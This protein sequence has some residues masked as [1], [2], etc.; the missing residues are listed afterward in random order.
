MEKIYSSA[1]QSQ[2]GD[3]MKKIIL[4]FVFLNFLF[5]NSFVLADEQKT[6]TCPLLSEGTYKHGQ[7]IKDKDGN[8]WHIWKD[9]GPEDL[10]NNVDLKNDMKSWKIMKVAPRENKKEIECR[11]WSDQESVEPFSIILSKSGGNYCKTIQ[12]PPPQDPKDYDF[13]WEHWDDGS[14]THNQRDCN[15]EESCSVTCFFK[16]PEQ[17]DLGD[18][19]NDKEL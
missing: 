1:Q 19:N 9:R 18:T 3:N 14:N 7:A 11:F 8:E 16:N 2:I 6:Y 10:Q 17:K 13:T 15:D 4:L 5:F 12:F